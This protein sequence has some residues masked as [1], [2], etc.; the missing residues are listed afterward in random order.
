MT[1]KAVT[2]ILLY[3]KQSI[4]NV[5]YIILLLTLKAFENRWNFKL[6]TS[7]I[8]VLNAMSFTMGQ[9]KSFAIYLIK[10]TESLTRLK[11]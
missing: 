1:I 8:I 9:F 6:S 10:A 11:V 3:Y 4:D 5:F 2:L 7:K